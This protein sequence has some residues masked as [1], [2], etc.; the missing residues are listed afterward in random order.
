MPEQVEKTVLATQDIEELAVHYLA[1]AGIDVALRFVD[2]AEQAFLQ[3]ARMPRMGARL[4]F[5]H[6]AHAHIR[7][8]HIQGFPRLLILYGALVNGIQVIR[9]L[10]AARDM[11]ALFDDVGFPQP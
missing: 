8:W 6:P 4:G 3:L 1:E 2:H 9:V 10:D 5:Q 7:R 11:N